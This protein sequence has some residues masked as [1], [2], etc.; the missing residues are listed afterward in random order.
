MDGNSLLKTLVN[1]D[2]IVVWLHN[3]KRQ[4]IYNVIYEIKCL[5]DD[6]ITQ[7]YVQ[8]YECI[9]IAFSGHGLNNK[10]IVMRDGRSNADVHKDILTPLLPGSIPKF[11]N[12]SKVLLIDACRGS[13]ETLGAYTKASSMEAMSKD[14]ITKDAIPADGNFLLAYAT[15]PEHYS[16]IYKSGSMWIQE[17][18]KLASYSTDSIVSVLTEVNEKL[19]DRANAFPGFALQQP[20]MIG[21]L[22]RNV[23]IR[24]RDQHPNDDHVHTEF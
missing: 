5:V 21:R 16:Y 18:A 1:S 15:L 3:I 24:H 6:T 8:K 4:A 23:Y 17:F 14:V 20:E 22:S 12:V 11:G 19:L 2:F 9:F 10:Y 13:F 7:R